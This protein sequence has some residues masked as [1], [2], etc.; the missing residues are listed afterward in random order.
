M[1]SAL[2]ELLDTDLRFQYPEPPKTGKVR[3]KAK[4]HFEVPQ[5]ASCQVRLHMASGLSA[6]RCC[7]VKKS[8]CGELSASET[9]LSAECNVAKIKCSAVQR[10][11]VL[12]GVQQALTL[13]GELG[14]AP[15]VCL[16]AS[17]KCLCEVQRG[18]VQE[19]LSATCFSAK[20]LCLSVVLRKCN[21]KL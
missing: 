17:V 4:V 9:S 16:S 3:V 11:Q 5:S 13:W 1:V 15:E 18:Q 8:L 21:E 19:H 6:L 2:G 20:C 10:L 12:P 7:I 14:A